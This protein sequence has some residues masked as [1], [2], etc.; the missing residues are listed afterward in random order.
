MSALNGENTF[1]NELQMRNRS[2]SVSSYSNKVK[3]VLG[4]ETYL[5]FHIAEASA[6]FSWP[7][8]IFQY[9]RDIREIIYPLS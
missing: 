1:P 4:G 9:F 7:C 6:F 3:V 2:G 5:I 8:G